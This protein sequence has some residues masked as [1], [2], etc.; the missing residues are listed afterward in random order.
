MGFA[1][2]I[3]T[4]RIQCLKPLGCGSVADA[5]RCYRVVNVIAV[6][7]VPGVRLRDGPLEVVVL[8]PAD[9]VRVCRGVAPGA[10]R[11][12]PQHVGIPDSSR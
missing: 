5:R 4:A 11:T 6:P 3:V 12:R 7:R 10:R 8:A 9:P 1:T 2:N